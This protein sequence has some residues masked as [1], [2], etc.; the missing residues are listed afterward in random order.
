MA[1]DEHEKGK[2]GKL[3]KVVQEFYT[4]ALLRCPI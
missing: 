2:S 4:S 1:A 3:L